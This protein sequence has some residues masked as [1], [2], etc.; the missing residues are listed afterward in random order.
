[1]ALIGAASLAFVLYGHPPATARPGV[2]Y[3][4]ERQEAATRNEAAAWI[5]AQVERTAVIACDQAMCSALEADGFAAANLR[6]LGQTAPYPVSSSLVVE[7]AFVRN[8]FGSSL[9]SDWAPAVLASFG[10]GTA[11]ITVRVIAPHGAKA[12]YAA[13]AADQLSR[14]QGG[15]ELLHSS[16]ITLSASAKQDLAAGDVDSRLVVAIIAMAGARPIDVIQF[17]NVGTGAS[18]GIPL[19]YVDLAENLPTAHLAAA[20][21]VQSLLTALVPVTQLYGQVTHQAVVLAGGITALQ[22]AF[23]APSP[24]GVFAPKG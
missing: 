7:T 2:S 14:K 22:I 17:G 13:A 23:P 21:Y 24:F 12:F 4:L 19:R 15:A 6:V 3:V 9:D 1:V 20:T 16:Q 18:P 8:I 5:V 11:M 10:S